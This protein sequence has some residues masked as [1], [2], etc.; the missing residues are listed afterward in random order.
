[1]RDFLGLSP[2]DVTDWKFVEFRDVSPGPWARF[3]ENNDFVINARST[4]EGVAGKNG[5][6]SGPTVIT[7]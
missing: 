3:G 7:R 2:I 5:T 4:T 6:S 1:M